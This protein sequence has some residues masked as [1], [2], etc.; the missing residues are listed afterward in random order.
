[1]NLKIGDSGIVFPLKSGENLFYNPK[2]ILKP[3]LLI[4]SDIFKLSE[5]AY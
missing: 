2:E 4:I 3:V 5:L 1:M